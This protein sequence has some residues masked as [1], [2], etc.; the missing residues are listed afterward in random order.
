MATTGGGHGE[1][2]AL[3]ATGSWGVSRVR[4]RIRGAS[5][6]AKPVLVVPVGRVR[7]NTRKA[8]RVP[9]TFHRS[10]ELVRPVEPG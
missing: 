1:L 2:I 10:F 4:N 3:S 5:G 8:F 7:N 6:I 9:T